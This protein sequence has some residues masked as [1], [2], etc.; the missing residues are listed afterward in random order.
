[1]HYKA[2]DIAHLTDARYFA[3]MGAHWLGFPVPM[4]EEEGAERAYVRLK[5]MVSWVE[6]PKPVAELPRQPTAAEAEQI[7]LATGLTTL[8]GPVDFSSEAL[9]PLPPG[10]DYLPFFSFSASL[11]APDFLR[12][13]RRQLERREAFAKY[14]VLRLEGGLPPPAL[15]LLPEVLAGLPLIL[16]LDW[17]PALLQN[18]RQSWDIPAV[19]FRG[20]AEEA[21]GVKSYEELE[22]LLEGWE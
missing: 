21:P 7:V 15:S 10:A 5:E 4:P 17:T 16:E 18:V 1:M 13:L 2:T 9:P 20:G 3:A 19:Q 8:Q 11:C 12:D 6:G 22:L 14:M